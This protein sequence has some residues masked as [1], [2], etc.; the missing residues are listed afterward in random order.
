MGDFITAVL[1][2]S[3]ART[4][5]D[6]TQACLGS[7]YL[8][9]AM[10]IVPHLLAFPG[11]FSP[12]P[13][14]GGPDSA[15]WLWIFWHGGFAVGIINFAVRK[16]VVSE[17]PIAIWPFV[18]GTVTVAVATALL[19]T[20]GSRFL[21]TILVDGSYARMTELG[22]APAVMASTI[23]ALALTLWR[24]R[25][26]STVT[27]WLAVAM[28]ALVVD[29]G[30][31][32]LGVGRLSLGWYLGRCLS[33]VAGFSVLCALLTDLVRLFATVA[34]ANLYLE[35]LSLTDALTEIANRRSFEQ[36]LEVEWRRAQREQVPMSLVMIDIDHFKRYNDR[37]GHPAGDECL[38]TVAATLTKHARRPWDMPA[39]LGGEEFAVLLPTTEGDGAAKVAEMFRACIEELRLP[40]PDNGPQI[41]TISVGVA[42]VY[43]HKADQM[44]AGL[45]A[46]A[47][48]ALYVAKTTGRNRFHQHVVP[49]E[50]D[51]IDGVLRQIDTVAAVSAELAGRH[52]V[53]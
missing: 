10:T 7:A 23:I 39:R 17:R 46:A 1:L 11:V 3:Q 45:M 43:P 44:P 41:M 37:F 19:A 51:V 6:T 32:I 8:F 18:F 20:V 53:E 38:R 49:G 13:L 9:S 14:I 48:A 5:N 36:R 22:I 35:K 16:P 52:G 24:L 21:P 27:I 2:F 25:Q 29:V 40:H 26:A 30:L 4:S 42:T 47:D 15:V 12:T 50:Q 31:T 28:V 34:K 33:L